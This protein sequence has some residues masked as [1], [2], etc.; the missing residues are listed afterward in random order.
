MA[1]AVEISLEYIAT[2]SLSTVEELPKDNECVTTSTLN[3]GSEVEVG[4][5]A[6]SYRV[7]KR[8][9]IGL[10]QIVALTML[11]SWNVSFPKHLRVLVVGQN[12]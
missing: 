11:T 10:S 9:Y 5:I 1:P 8:R 4:Y 12:S 6:I 2:Q 3:H 7:Y